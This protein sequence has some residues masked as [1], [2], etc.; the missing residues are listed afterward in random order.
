MLPQL[1]LARM[2]LARKLKLKAA[3]TD[4]RGPV[5]SNLG[6]PL[7]CDDCCEIGSCAPIIL[8]RARHEM[9]DVGF[10]H[11]GFLPPMAAR[12]RPAIRPRISERLE[13]GAFFRDCAQEI[14]EIAR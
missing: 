9:G 11:A 4:I 6:S 13:P 14:Q 2:N 12:P 3:Y 5:A 1:N 7:I 10:L 8:N